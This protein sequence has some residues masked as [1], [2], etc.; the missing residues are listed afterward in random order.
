M[1]DKTAFVHTLK[2]QQAICGCSSARVNR[3]PN[4]RRSFWDLS[5]SYFTPSRSAG[6]QP[7][8]E[9]WNTDNLRRLVEGKPLADV[10]H[11]PPGR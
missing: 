10:V 11:T 2:T 4:R 9:D 3:A 8:T 6:S 1:I 7:K 5:R